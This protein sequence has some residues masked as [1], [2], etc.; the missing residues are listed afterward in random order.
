MIVL[1]AQR[2][3]TPLWASLA[4][5]TSPL[6]GPLGVLS[7]RAT[8]ALRPTCNSHLA[9][10]KETGRRF[11]RRLMTPRAARLGSAPS[12]RYEYEYYRTRNENSRRIT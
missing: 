7:V 8:A 12:M 1:L 11:A 2:F 5:H 6:N 4:R 3:D 10:K 9:L